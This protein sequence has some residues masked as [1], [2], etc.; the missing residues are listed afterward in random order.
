MLPGARQLDLREVLGE[1]P[2]G[3]ADRHLVVVDHDQHLRLALA[4]VVE[5][6]ERQPA[7]QRRVADDDR[8][9]LEPVA[10]VARLGEA[11]GDRQARPGVPAVEDVV[12]RLGAAREAADAVEL[13]QRPEPLEPAGQ[14]LVRVG[15]VAGVPDDPVARR[16]EQ[17][18]ERD[19]QLDH[20]ERRPEMAAGLR[21]GPDD[22]VADL[23]RQLG[24]LDLVEAAQVGRVLD[25]R[26][27]RHGGSNSWGLRWRPGTVALTDRPSGV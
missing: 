15:L 9:P 24:E 23:D 19:G 12:R 26:Q 4:D 18:V 11:L 5:R 13:A 6:L 21:H 7:H 3:R 2:D 10:Q 27:D 20:A 17:A 22:R 25:G 16:F 14:Q 1:R 8:D